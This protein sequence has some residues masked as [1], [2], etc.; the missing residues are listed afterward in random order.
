[1]VSFLVSFCDVRTSQNVEAA[2]PTLLQSAECWCPRSEDDTIGDLKK[3]VAAQTGTRPEKIR[4][5]K[6]YTIYKVSK[7]L[8]RQGLLGSFPHDPNTPHVPGCRTT[9]RWRIMRFTTAWA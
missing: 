6:W 1:M 2:P 9:S 5:Q 4:I 7:C 8:A 3:L